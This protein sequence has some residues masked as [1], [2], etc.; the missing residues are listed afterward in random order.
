MGELEKLQQNITALIERY[1]ALQQENARLQQLAEQQRDEILRTHSELVETQ[2]KYKQLQIAHAVS[3][4]AENRERAK[5]QI[6]ALIQRVDYAI[7]V[8]KQ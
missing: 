4:S 1:H 6:S 7:D 2:N 5:Q 8:L 3:A